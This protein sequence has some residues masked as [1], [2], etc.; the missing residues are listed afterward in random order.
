MDSPRNAVVGLLIPY[1]SLL[2]EQVE[3]LDID[4][5]VAS[6][7]RGRLSSVTTKGAITR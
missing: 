4:N 5:V 1:T 7:H 3:D 2:V 6:A